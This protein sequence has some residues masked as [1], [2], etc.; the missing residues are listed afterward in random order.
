[1]DKEFKK[2]IDIVVGLARLA[3]GTL[4]IIGSIG[5]FFFVQSALDPNAVI[6][7]NGVP[8]TEQNSKLVA[9]LFAAIFPM[10]GMVLSFAPSKKMDKWTSKII[11]YLCKQ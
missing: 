5:V 7:I 8:T 4:I 1:M 11:T 10:F 6:E 2:K 3:G 9:V